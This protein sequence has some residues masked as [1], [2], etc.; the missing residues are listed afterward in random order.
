[1]KTLLNLVAVG[2]VSLGLHLLVNCSGPRSTETPT[3]PKSAEL[4][5][6]SAE[7]HTFQTSPKFGDEL[8]HNMEDDSIDLTVLGKIIIIDS[9][10]T[11]FS[12]TS[13][14]ISGWGNDTWEL[15][16]TDLTQIYDVTITVTDCCC[17]GDYYEVH[18]DGDLIGTTPNLAPPWGCDFSGPLSSGSFAVTLCPGTHIITVRDAG[19]DGH[20]QIEIEEQRMCPAGFTVSGSL[21]P[22]SGAAIV[23]PDE[24]FIPLQE[25]HTDDSEVKGLQEQVQE[26]AP[27]VVTN[28]RGIQRLLTKEA[29]KAGVSAKA[30]ALGHKLVVL[31]NRIVRAAMR[32]EDVSLSA[33]DFAFIEPLFLHQAQQGNP[34]GDRQNPTPCPPWI[35]SGN[36]FSTEEEVREHLISLEYHLTARYARGRSDR[37]YTLVVPH[38]DC[39]TGPFR[40]HAIIGMYGPCWTYRTQGP[41]PNPEIISYLGSWPYFSW[42]AYVRWWHREFC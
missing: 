31:N 2:L 19:F 35:E 39:G 34:C 14:C 42:P 32:D 3:S 24:I 27:F 37:D 29:V 22:Y 4:G 13:D 15:Q 10:W 16:L 21:S 17:P 8:K 36:F 6:S 11:T 30:I 18:V 1:M 7:T 23:T 5:L 20:S 41:E 9:D 25:S 33:S 40:S 38:P 28:E 26:V 12:S